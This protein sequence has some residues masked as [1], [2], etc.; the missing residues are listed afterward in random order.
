[1][2]GELAMTDFEEEGDGC[3]LIGMMA[4]AISGAIV[5]TICGALGAI[6][7]IVW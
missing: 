7:F 3:I 1:M 5:G 4:C 6:L 2:H